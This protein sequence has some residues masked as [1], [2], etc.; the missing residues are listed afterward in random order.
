LEAR[1]RIHRRREEE[2][3]EEKEKSQSD[4]I[5]IPD[6]IRNHLPHFVQAKNFD[7]I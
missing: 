6:A 1:R 2:R 4:G 7:R 3:K 5:D